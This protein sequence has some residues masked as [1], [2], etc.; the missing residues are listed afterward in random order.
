MHGKQPWQFWEDQPTSQDPPGAAQPQAPTANATPTGSGDTV[1]ESWTVPATCQDWGADW[2]K[3]ETELGRAA[4]DRGAYI[5]VSEACAAALADVE[6][7]LGELVERKQR[8]E[9]LCELAEQLAKVAARTPRG[10][11]R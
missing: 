1:Q 4:E 3:I 11:L 5:A 9:D 10:T 6:A 8:L 2:E 7:L